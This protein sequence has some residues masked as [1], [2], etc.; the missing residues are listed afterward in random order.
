MD[1]KNCC[2]F[3]NEHEQPLFHVSN[4]LRC[5]LKIT[6]MKL[7]LCSSTILYLYMLKSPSIF[8]KHLTIGELVDTNCLFI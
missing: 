7:A 6:N 5:V 1:L 2:E 3:L 8:S 4:I